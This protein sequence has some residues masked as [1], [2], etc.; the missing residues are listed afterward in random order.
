[1]GAMRYSCPIRLVP[2]CYLQKKEDFW[3]SFSPIALKLRD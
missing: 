3:E 1:M 2:D